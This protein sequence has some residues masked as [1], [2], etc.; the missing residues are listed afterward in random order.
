VRDQHDRLSLLLQG[1]DQ[2]LL[3]FPAHLRVERAERLVHKQDGR[4]LRQRPGDGDAL[5][6]AAGE[7]AG[8]AVGEAVEV[9][10]PQQ[11]HGA[12][13]ALR[14]RDA[15]KLHAVLDVLERREP[16]KGCVGLEDHAAV[17]TRLADRLAVGLDGATRR[18]LEP[19]D[20][21][22]HRRLA[23]AG[24]AEKG[25]DL[26][27]SQVEANVLD[28]GELPREVLFGDVR[29]ANCGPFRMNGGGFLLEAVHGSSLRPSPCGS[30]R[31]RE[32]RH[33][34]TAR[35]SARRGRRWK[36]CRPLSRPP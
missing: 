31:R 23:A 6:H 14:P 24:R 25:R 12:V 3:H 5:P 11:L 35:R 22:Q 13:A 15:E 17:G 21:A 16:G 2:H 26:V 28:R 18:V 29:R 30:R 32:S 27:L 4:V 10:L 19:G 9:E 8:I 1:F 36:E 20:H 34:E 7:L 33:P